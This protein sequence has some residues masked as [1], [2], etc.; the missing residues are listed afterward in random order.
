MKTRRGFLLAT[1]A[2]FVAGQLAP[3][4]RRRGGHVVGAS[5]ERGHLL[6]DGVI[7]EAPDD[8]TTTDVVIIGGGVS[9]LSAAWRLGALGI[10]CVVLELESFIGGTSSY[11]EDGA[12]PHPFGAHYLP[13]PNVEARPAL[14]LLE[15]MGVLRSWD[16]AGRPQFDP[17]VLCH[18]P[19]DRVFYRGAWHIGLVPPSLPP[20]ER[21]ELR[22]FLVQVEGLTE[23]RGSDG[24]YFFQIPIAESSRDPE[25]LALDAI[26]MQA[27]LEQEGFRTPFLHWYVRYA[28]LDDFG[29]DPSDVSAWAGLHYF[30]ARKLES[31]QLQGSHYLVW[32]EGNGH[33]VRALVD[34]AHARIEHDAIAL[35]VDA[36]DGGV[37]V[38][39]RDGD[40]ARTRKVNA[41]GAVIA[42]PGFIANRLVGAARTAPL[43]RKSSPWLVANL[44]VK[45]PIDPNAA[46]D[47]VLYDA[48]GL[49]YVDAAHQLTPPREQT[50][51]TYF[52]AYG[53]QDVT[54]RRRSLLDRSWESFAREVFEDLAPAHPD[55][56]TQTSRIDFAVWGHA[57]PRPT[58]GFL[59]AAPFSPPVL[60]DERVAWAS[61]DQYGIALFEEAQRAGVVAAETIAEV[62][63]KDVP[64]TWV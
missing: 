57:M 55:L 30:A 47:S 64:E 18:A 44:H 53:E 61:V 5:H 13:A 52:R 34:R 23:R 3:D 16:A 8:T 24:K 2:G 35:A 48:E 62:V 45:R 25:A 51:L 28:T 22:R 14:R 26:T 63:G 27:W 6:R 15:D 33:L 1:A 43:L 19:D 49:G 32:P 4:A 40:T 31:P 56:V 37:S 7:L 41:R 59:G 10:D 46:W 20:E 9:G 36:R 11:G 50:V 42:T 29:G 54:A 21:D 58:Q 60:L 17:R 12:V 38:T 39:Y